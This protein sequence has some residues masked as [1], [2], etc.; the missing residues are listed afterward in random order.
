M[1]YY[2]QSLLRLKIKESVLCSVL[3]IKRIG[4]IAEVKMRSNSWAAPSANQLQP[5]MLSRVSPTCNSCGEVVGAAQIEVKPD[6]IERPASPNGRCDYTAL[7]AA[8]S[9]IRLKD[10]CRHG[11]VNREAPYRSGNR[12]SPSRPGD[13]AT[14]LPCRS[15]ASAKRCS[16]N[17]P[18]SRAP[19]L[20][21]CRAV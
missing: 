1:F 9:S 15:A 21:R 18:W 11:D 2:Y 13:P 5:R 3:Q 8:L 4:Y 14:S 7:G 12:D 16:A 20:R 19:G 17:R 6:G 10:L